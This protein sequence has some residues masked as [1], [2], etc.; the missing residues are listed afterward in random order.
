MKSIAG[1]ICLAS[2]CGGTLWV[3]YQ[4]ISRFGGVFVLIGGASALA[5]LS[6]A[7]IRAPEGHED[8]YGLYVRPATRRVQAQSSCPA[9]STTR[10]ARTHVVLRAMYNDKHE[11]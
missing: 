10:A 4:A 5:V 11:A 1:L 7:L 9:V 6:G 2:F 3:E 8:A